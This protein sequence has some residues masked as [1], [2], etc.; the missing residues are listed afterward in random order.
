MKN[1][2]AILL[3]PI[4]LS[5]QGIN[6]TNYHHAANISAVRDFVVG[7]S[8]T[9]QTRLLS[10]SQLAALAVGQNYR[11]ASQF[12][13]LGGTNHDEVAIQA[14]INWSATNK[15][16]FAIDLRCVVGTNNIG[17]VNPVSGTTQYY[18]LNMP[19]GST[20]LLL[21][22]IEIPTNYN[23][24][25]VGNT[26][27]RIAPFYTINPE[28]NITLIGTEQGYIEC[29]GGGTNKGPYEF[30]NTN[31]I[32]TFGVCF[33]GCS[34]LTVSDVILKNPPYMGFLVGNCVKTRMRNLR[35]EQDNF[36][37]WST[38]V[39]HFGHDGLHMWEPLQDF[40]CDGIETVNLDDNPVAFCAGEAAANYSIVNA[41]PIKPWGWE[42]LSSYAGNDIGMKNVHVRHVRI[43][44]SLQNCGVWGY[45]TD[46]NSSLS[47]VSLEDVRGDVYTGSV[48]GG[49]TGGSA[50]FT[51]GC[52]FDYFRISDYH[53]TGGGA[54]IALMDDPANGG[55]I[56]LD[57]IDFN[58]L[59]YDF[60]PSGN[61]FIR[62]CASNIVINGTTATTTNAYPYLISTRWTNSVSGSMFTAP[63]VSINNSHLNGFTYLIGDSPNMTSLTISGLNGALPLTNSTAATY[64]GDG[65]LRF[66]GTNVFNITP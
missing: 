40:D 15:G 5:A 64:S 35:D 12:G 63:N 45:P 6:M 29:N 21:S 16:V 22:P 44:H 34:N 52:R 56:E 38:Y 47:D 26:T 7:L 25:A 27:P 1:L 4:V 55:T 14:G 20:L 66:S 57:N 46:G 30:F 3:L 28:T 58:L 31:N 10:A 62:V 2:L 32:G 50:G 33:L 49:G 17:Q 18:G 53:V 51:G 37:D 61:P 39:E 43:H 41:R 42:R 11:T 13:A 48:M 19:S 9:N 65:F 54:G 36:Y 60:L 23:I 24:T 8:D 59:P